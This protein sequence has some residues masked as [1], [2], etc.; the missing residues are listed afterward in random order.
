QRFIPDTITKQIEL[1]EW[2]V[3]NRTYISPAH[4]HGELKRGTAIEDIMPNYE[5]QKVWDIV[6]DWVFVD[7]PD[8]DFYFVT[9]Y[10]GTGIS[11]FRDEC[12]EDDPIATE[13]IHEKMIVNI[14]YFEP[15]HVMSGIIT[16]YW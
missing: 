12:L 16:D 14:A 11:T 7:R 4:I 8:L 1:L 2:L 15:V 5:T 13:Y 9:G 3:T 10:G 6:K